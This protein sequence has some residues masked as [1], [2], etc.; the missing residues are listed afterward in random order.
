[1]S[2]IPLEPVDQTKKNGD[3]RKTSL[4]VFQLVLQK[5]VDAEFMLQGR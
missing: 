4:R 1:M 2:L 3:Q 5:G